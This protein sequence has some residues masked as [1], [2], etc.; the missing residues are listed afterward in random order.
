MKGLEKYISDLKRFPNVLFLSSKDESRK[1]PSSIV[2]FSKTHI[3]LLG[4]E[5]DSSILEVYNKIKYVCLN[6]VGGAY[7]NLDSLLIKL[8]QLKDGSITFNGLLLDDVKY[9]DKYYLEYSKG[10]EAAFNNYGLNESKEE[11]FKLA[12]KEQKH[13][14]F[15]LEKFKTA[16]SSINKNSFFYGIVNAFEDGYK[17]GQ[18]YKAWSLILSNSKEYERF[19]KTFDYDLTAAEFAICFVYAYQMD[20]LKG[21]TKK[22]MIE[23]FKDK[24]V[25]QASSY[26]IRRVQSHEDNYLEKLSEEKEERI[27]SF[28]K[29]EYGLTVADQFK[30]DLT[31]L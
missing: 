17:E 23:G 25:R 8:D 29:R 20:M 22:E 2:P 6:G 5:V 10:F 30:H 28:L 11:I 12:T 13:K 4:K 18:I 9:L 19:F 26:F 7:H 15:N 24:Y 3:H 1:S 14:G 16:L 31:S 27:F 21:S